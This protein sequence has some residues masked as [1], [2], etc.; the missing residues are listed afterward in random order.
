MKITEMVTV[1]EYYV[2][3]CKK[4]KEKNLSSIDVYFEPSA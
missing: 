2:L 3:L 1:G 4:K